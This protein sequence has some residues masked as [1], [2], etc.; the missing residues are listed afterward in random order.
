MKKVF[1]MLSVTLL[2]LTAC[3]RSDDFD[4]LM[5]EDAIGVD[6]YYDQVDYENP[7][8][9]IQFE[10]L[11]NGRQNDMESAFVHKVND[12]ID[13]VRMVA[14]RITP[15][16]AFSPNV[17]YTFQVYITDVTE[18]GVLS[19]NVH[20][21]DKFNREVRSFTLYTYCELDH[22]FTERIFDSIEELGEH[23]GKNIRYGM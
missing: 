1:L 23:L 10:R 16:A 20:V 19:A 4:F 15:E 13:N 11:L 6:F 3:H 22:S 7:A 2:S 8:V 14:Y 18:H 9:Q 12:E 5:G 21:F 17:N